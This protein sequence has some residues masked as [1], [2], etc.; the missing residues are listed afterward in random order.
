MKNIIPSFGKTVLTAALPAFIFFVSCAPNAEER[1]KYERA[2]YA[3]S[4]SVSAPVS[5]MAADNTSS[6][7]EEHVFLRKADLKFSVKDVGRSTAEIENI[8]RK[9]NG[10]ITYTKL[11]GSKTDYGATRVS[12]DSVIQIASVT[13]V[14]EIT[15]RVPNQNLDSTL[16]EINRQVEFMDNRTIT[17]DDVKLQLLSAKMAMKRNKN[18]IKKLNNV[19][20][21]QG[22]KL[23]ETVNAL[24]NLANETGAND[25][26]ELSLLDLN[27]QVNYSTVTLYI[28]QPG[29]K[30][31]KKA[32][33]IPAI[34][35]YTPSFGDKIKSASAIGLEI[36]EGIAIFFV[37]IWPFIFLTVV[38]WVLVKWLNRKK[39]F[40][41]MMQ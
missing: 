40:S 13:V 6:K 9:Q 16:I 38:I 15:L 37:T 17:A 28:Y 8:V 31:Y 30:E 23:N 19:I 10:F 27:D 32:E 12:K 21:Q 5:Q 39:V 2:S 26:Q 29:K 3:M 36:L 11:N 41:R 7:P 24:E 4:D 22:K 1:G 33:F 34:E 14:N 20:D 18:H 25:A 35:P